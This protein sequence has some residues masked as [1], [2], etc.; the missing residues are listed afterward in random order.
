MTGLGENGRSIRREG[1]AI[2]ALCA[3]A[4][5][6]L[7]APSADAK[8]KTKVYSSG[9]IG[10]PIPDGGGFSEPIRTPPIRIGK[11]G[12][13]RDVNVAVRI[14]HPDT[15]QLDVSVFDNNFIGGYL[16]DHEPKD[17]PTP[18]SPDL[19]AGPGDCTGSFTIF[20]DQAPLAI[21]AATNPYLGSFV[22]TFESLP[23]PVL[24]G[25]RGKSLEGRYRLEV[26]DSTAGRT[27]YVNC[28]E[29]II[30]YNPKKEGRGLL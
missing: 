15:T 24:K 11:R 19:G 23:D 18:L 25:F 14:T 6:A 3:V 20:D 4:M 8:L 27:G 30:R 10:I 9:P 1:I 17:G 13:I 16:F 22:P 7:A 28:W 12:K 2:A 5:L 21:S 29:L 26:G